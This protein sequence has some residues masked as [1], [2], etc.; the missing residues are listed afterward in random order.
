[1]CWASHVGG[2][3]LVKR[4]FVSSTVPVPVCWLAV[5]SVFY[6]L[7]SWVDSILCSVRFYSLLSGEQGCEWG[8]TLYSTS[9]LHSWCWLPVQ[10]TLGWVSAAL[11]WAAWQLPGVN[12]V[13]RC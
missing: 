9:V 10:G 2:F 6:S 12:P 13:V 8:S 3:F 5:L 4:V 7:L 1:M 11:W